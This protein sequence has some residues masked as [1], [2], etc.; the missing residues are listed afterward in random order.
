MSDTELGRWA[1]SKGYRPRAPF[2]DVELAKIRGL[3]GYYLVGVDD[4]SCY[5]GISTNDVSARLRSHRREK[6]GGH[7]VS[8][9]VMESDVT[10]LRPGEKKLVESAEASGLLVH[11]IEWASQI[12]GPS[13]LDVVVNVKTQKQWRAAPKIVNHKHRNSALP[14][15]SPSKLVAYQ[16]KFDA[17]MARPDADR[18]VAVLAQYLNETICCPRETEST[19]WTVSCT[20]IQG[21]GRIFC[22]SAAMMELFTVREHADGTIGAFFSVRPKFVARTRT[23]RVMK[24]AKLRVS[25]WDHGYKDGAGEQAQIH[26]KGLDR[27]ERILLNSDV[28][29]GAAQ[30]NLDIMRRRK[31]GYRASHCRQLAEA[32]L[33]RRRLPLRVGHLTVP[34]SSTTSK[35]W[36]TRT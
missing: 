17:L 27:L 12:T 28:L 19:F 6:F 23:K 25:A 33:D 16:A 26:V 34:A 3:R 2:T 22:V 11:N 31:S 36:P 21:S 20:P 9:W 7:A 5:I 1:L 18:L 15:F 10:D 8:F 29:N 14:D 24:Y 13:S 32:A 30:F 35:P 4:G